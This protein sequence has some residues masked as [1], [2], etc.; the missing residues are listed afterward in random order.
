MYCVHLYQRA[1]FWK[2]SRGPPDPPAFHPS[3]SHRSGT[4]S[5]SRHAQQ[6]IRPPKLPSLLLTH[7]P[8]QHAHARTAPHPSTGVL[9]LRLGPCFWV[10][11]LEGQQSR[12]K[13]A[14]S[15]HHS[16]DSLKRASTTSCSS[17]G[18]HMTAAYVKCFSAA[19]ACKVPKAIMSKGNSQQ[20]Q[21]RGGWEKK[22]KK[23]WKSCYRPVNTY[24][25][26]NFCRATSPQVLPKVIQDYGSLMFQLKMFP[27]LFKYL[28]R[29]AIF[30]YAIGLITPTS[31]GLSPYQCPTIIT[32]ISPTQ[33]ERE[34][35]I[36]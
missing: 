10:S 12:L 4:A 20:Q 16:K 21:L 22:K 5:W 27:L 24:S 26:D 31:L 19:R 3:C 25:S 35:P 23:R 30:I 18:K 29:R 13:K 28:T 17:N 34:K 33:M 6:H 36:S 1:L 14:A 11:S 9:W 15:G 32:K 7:Q 2:E 8:L